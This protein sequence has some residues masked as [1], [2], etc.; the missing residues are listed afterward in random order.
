MQCSIVSIP[1]WFSRNK[2]IKNNDLIPY[3]VSIPL[4]FSRNFCAKMC[5]LHWIKCFHTTMVLTQLCPRSSESNALHS[6]PYHY[7]SHATKFW[8]RSELKTFHVSIPLWFSRNSRETLR[9]HMTESVSIPLW[10]S[11]NGTLLQKSYGCKTFPYHYGS[12]A[13]ARYYVTWVWR[14]RSFHT[15]MVLTQRFCW[16]SGERCFGSF[17]TTMVLTQLRLLEEAYRWRN[18]FHT[19]MVL[20]QRWDSGAWIKFSNV[21]I[22]LWFSRNRLRPKRLLWYC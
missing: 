14:T 8:C 9:A 10:F 2:Y 6:F 21:S 15:T 20:T 1:L 18:S 12:H 11:R 16:E 3:T 22:P 13:T 17:H 19:T 5:V 4:W 7:G